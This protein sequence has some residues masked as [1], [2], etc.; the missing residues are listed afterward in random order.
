[1]VQSARSRRLDLRIAADEKELIER[2]AALSGNNTADFV[3]SATLQAA[4]EAIRSHDVIELTSESSRVFVEALIN[5]PEPN[6]HLRSLMK[7]FGLEV[8]H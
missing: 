7:E 2:A 6:E 5:P 8:G 1:M 3:R 4:R